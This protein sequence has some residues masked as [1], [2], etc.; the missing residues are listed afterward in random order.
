MRRRSGKWSRSTSMRC[1][2]PL[3]MQRSPCVFGCSKS[4]CARM[5]Q[6]QSMKSTQLQH[7][8]PTFLVWLLQVT[9]LI[10]ELARG[11]AAALGIDMADGYVERLHAYSRSVAHFPTA[12]KE[13]KW[14]NGWF[15]SHT[16]TAKA[17]GKRDPY[18]T[19]T[20]WLTELGVLK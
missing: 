15:H 6:Y 11:G 13:F 4:P 20:K 3:G 2:L 10:E 5:R 19:H 18:P 8:N 16:K 14:R 17:E 9:L 12:V 1:I 7:N